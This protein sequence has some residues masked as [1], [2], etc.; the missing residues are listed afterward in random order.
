MACILKNRLLYF[1]GKTTIHLLLLSVVF[2]FAP[3]EATAQRRF[4]KTYPASRDVRVTLNNR[5]GT[6]TVEGWNRNEVQVQAY[7]ESPAAEINPQVL[8]G[9]I[10]I[11]V[12]KDNYGRGELGSV[13]FM[14]RVPFDAAV[15]IETKIGNLN[16][17]SVRGTLVRAKISSD[18]DITLTNISAP[19]VTAENGIGN[20]FF[21]GDIQPN[22][23]YRFT[24]MRG[25]IN[26]RVP[27]NSSFK[28]IAT[29]PSTRSINLGSFANGN[30]RF[31]GDGR[32]VMGQF[33]DGSSSITVT[34]Q[35]GTIAFI[36]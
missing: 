4:S 15:D 32:R 8:K 36:R 17:S 29:A 19:R 25:D 28:L 35:R 22:G 9:V 5:S 14:I 27:L 13:N 26:L 12:V 1:T 10:F 30:M 21:D 18:G 2:L 6:V 16:V 3:G 31:V 20:I 34:N 33:G 24:S 7:L 23:V 11:N